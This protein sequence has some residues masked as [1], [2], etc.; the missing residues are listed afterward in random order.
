M[1]KRDRG[2]VCRE[3]RPKGLEDDEDLTSKGDKRVFTFKLVNQ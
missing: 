2:L 1:K 3:S